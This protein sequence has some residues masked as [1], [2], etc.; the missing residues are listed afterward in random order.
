[1]IVTPASVLSKGQLEITRGTNHSYALCLTQPVYDKTV[2]EIEQ[3][4]AD[5]KTNSWQLAQDLFDESSNVVY[6]AYWFLNSTNVAP[7]ANA[8]TLVGNFGHTK[9]VRVSDLSSPSNTICVY[10]NTVKRNKIVASWHEY[11]RRYVEFTPDQDSAWILP[12]EPVGV[13][14]RLAQ[15]VVQVQDALPGFF[16]LT[17]QVNRVLVNVANL[18][19]NLNSTVADVHP[20]ATAALTNL[21]A[22]TSILREP[23]GVGV[24]ALGTNGPAQL[25]TAIANVNTLLVN[26]D[27]NVNSLVL[28]L[29]P[30]L[31]HVSD[32]TSNLNA[33]VHADSNMLMGISKTI[34][35]TDTFIQGLK[36]HWLL[37][38]AFKKKP[39]EKTETH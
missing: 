2:A 13:A 32:I 38:S 23:G 31:D 21:V 28:A 18:T 20:E 24:M 14:D 7:L 25:Q 35:D 12:V 34:S 39:P 37:R 10:N 22:M 33:Q 4:V 11:L 9:L 30:T 27:T 36:R 15:V 26:S 8:Y 19:S 17:N 5:E 1:M 3:V 6:P 16:A 29:L